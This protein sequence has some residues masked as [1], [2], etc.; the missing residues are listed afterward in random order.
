MP[1]GQSLFGYVID[2]TD[3]LNEVIIPFLFGI[4]FLVFIY[5]AIRYFVI[6]SGEED[7]R[8]KARALA[9]YS[10]AAFVFLIIFWGVVSLLTESLDFYWQGPV[11]PDYLTNMPNNPCASNGNRPFNSSLPL[12]PPSPPGELYGP[13]APQTMVDCV[14]PNGGP[15]TVRMSLSDC[16]AQLGN[17]YQ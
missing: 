3:F 15:T 1:P 10:I 12:P 13:P 7:G 11:C 8:E 17:P 14:L 6:E 2:I 5:N 9:L 4:A 16:R